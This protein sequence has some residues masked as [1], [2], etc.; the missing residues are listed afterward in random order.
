MS[1]D[2][3]R[4]MDLIAY[5]HI[6]W[7][8]PFQIVLALIFLWDSMGPSVFAGLAVMILLIPFNIALARKGKAYQVGLKAHNHSV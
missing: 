6:I 4:L 2:A 1:V 3:Q 7:S 5:L 8:G